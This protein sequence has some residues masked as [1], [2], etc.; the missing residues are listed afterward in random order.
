MLT[1]KSRLL[2]CAS[3]GALA[4]FSA[5]ALANPQVAPRIVLP[6]SAP[7]QPL[8]GP[9][10][11]MNVDE[12]ALYYYAQNNQ[13]NRVEAEVLRLR[14]L[15]P[16]WSP[17]ADLYH[18]RGY[19][20][21]QH[22]WDMF[23]AQEIAA[24]HE[25][26]A[27]RVALEPG[28]QPPLEL[29]DALERAELRRRLLADF[30]AG[31]MHRVLSA[32]ENDPALLD[33]DDLE[34]LWVA[35]SAYAREEDSTTA[36]QLFDVALRAA[37]TPDE[38]M[39][40]LYK[41]RDALA[42]GDVETLVSAGQTIHGVQPPMAQVFDRFAL[43]LFRDQL[44]RQL[45]AWRVDPAHAHA[46]NQQ[47][48]TAIEASWTG[49][50]Q[51]Q[52][53]SEV[54]AGDYELIGWARY[55]QGQHEAA[56]SLFQ[57]AL[58]LEAALSDD[59]AARYGAALSLRDLGR[60][61]EAVDLLAA[62]L[63]SDL[64]AIS[65]ATRTS[66][67]PDVRSMALYIEM[68]GNALYGL[69]GSMA[70]TPQRVARHTAY[71]GTLE[72]A[73]G[74]EA[75][76]WYAYRSAQLTPAAAWFSKSLEW[77]PSHSAAEGLVRSHWGLGE[78]DTARAD[79]ARYS[80]RFP[81]LAALQNDLDAQRTATRASASTSAPATPAAPSGLAAASQAQRAGNPRRCLSLLQ[82]A[83]PTHAVNL[84]RGWCLLDLGRNHEASLAFT[85]VFEAA[86]GTTKRDAG[87][88]RA[89]S[90][91]RQGRTFDALAI[92]RDTDLSE[93]QRAIVARSALADQAN[94][95][96]NAGHYGDALA[97]LDR[98]LRFANE[99]RDL[100]VLRAWSLLRLNALNEARALFNRLDQ[101]LS[102]RETQRGLA[103]LPQAMGQPLFGNN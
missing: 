91:L 89:L 101:Q 92:A 52:L 86:S 41:A 22:L 25:E 79:L 94:Q 49:I 70:L 33:D 14:T 97:A 1:I 21:D 55:A 44:G 26:V 48:I 46:L 76:G 51:N 39:G 43:D 42:V 67:T 27:R 82:S 31:Q 2:V 83:A 20:R 50:A 64:P 12:S 62:G 53:A 13:H 30:E 69:E 54:L 58:T 8:D 23:A 6:T 45:E 73:T 17:P 81:E 16:G 9:S 84:I 98:R 57:Q 63:P 7:T 32:V 88:G 66:A 85:T 74:A 29:M 100:T 37:Q 99:P 93:D 102:T 35:G 95:A 5:P 24:I 10:Q 40:T 18:G 4:A 71:V 96:F 36:V 103:A 87:Y 56:L 11:A 34:V 3:V 28:W 60:S 15:H 65:P 59:N 77:R 68:L 78:R 72:S 80:S 19:N 75:L 38:V 47:A 61:D 90:M